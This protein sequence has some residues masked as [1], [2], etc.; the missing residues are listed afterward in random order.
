M[1]LVHQAKQGKGT[2]GYNCH[3]PIQALGLRASL[4][5]K[6]TSRGQQ[7]Y[8]EQMDTPLSV[9]SLQVSSLIEPQT[10]FHYSL[11]ALVQPIIQPYNSTGLSLLV[12]DLGVSHIHSKS[13]DEKLHR[14]IKKKNVKKNPEEDH[15]PKAHHPLA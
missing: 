8:L 5:C 3:L 14:D 13:L 9:L 4:N 7:P 12:V 1:Q 11:L 2:P 10:G 6:P 15:K